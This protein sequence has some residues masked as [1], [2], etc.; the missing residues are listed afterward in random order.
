MSTVVTVDCGLTAADSIN[1]TLETTE[2]LPAVDTNPSNAA[3]TVESE[4][5][6]QTAANTIVCDDN[7]VPIKAFYGRRL[8]TNIEN[9]DTR[10][11]PKRQRKCP[12]RYV[13]ETF[14]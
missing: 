1:V 7:V 14:D 3:V 5:T 10:L 4:N 2:Q 13:N 9:A 12:V 11:R 6:G 8:A